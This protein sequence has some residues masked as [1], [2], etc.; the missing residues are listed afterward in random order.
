MDIDPKTA[1]MKIRRFVAIDD[2]GNIINPMIVT[3]QIHGGLAM[4]IAPAMY[5]ELI[6][7]DDGNIL[8]GTFMDYL[9]PTSVETPNWETGHT[10]TPSPHH[11][12]GAKGV[13]E[14]PTVG[15]P[16]A[17]A[18]AV[19]DALSHLGVTHVDIP[20]TPFKVWKILKEKGV[21]S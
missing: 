10:I 3:G 11:P 19:V 17:V 6:Y 16:P 4:G 15:A 2:C 12:L 20:V 14:S 9:L 13:A 5:E 8:N 21:I 1:E 18:N 7:D